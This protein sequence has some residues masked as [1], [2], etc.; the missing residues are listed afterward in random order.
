MHPGTTK[1]DA[2]L[3][4]ICRTGYLDPKGE[5]FAALI[6]A[7]RAELSAGGPLLYRYTGSEGHEGAFVACSFWLVE[8]LARAGRIGEAREMMEA[9][10][11]LTNDVGLLSEQI[12]PA[13]HE[14]LG[15]FPQGLSHLSLINAAAALHE[16]ESQD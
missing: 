12:D 14:F 5:K 7:I 11:A 8:A 15:N 2:S 1:L 4:R 9:M 6:D 16:A 10:V 3:V 13:T